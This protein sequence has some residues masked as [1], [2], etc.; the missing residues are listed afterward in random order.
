MNQGKLLKLID[1]LP[2]I[3]WEK[4]VPLSSLTT[5]KVGGPARL[6]CYPKSEDEVVQAVQAARGLH[7]P[8]HVLG[9]GSNVLA[10]DE[11]FDGLLIILTKYMR[12]LSF[13]GFMLQCEA[14][15]PIIQ[16]SYEAANRGLSGLEFACGIPGSIGGAVFMNAGAYECSIDSVFIS[17]RC[18]DQNNNIVILTKNEMDFGYRKSR[19]IDEGLIILSV[20]LQL[21]A[22]HKTEI[23]DLMQKYNLSRKQKQPLE[24]PS[25]GSFFKRPPGHYA[26]ALI[27]QAGLKGFR[28]NG[29]MVSE[30]HA[31]FLVNAGNAT[32]ADFLQLCH[33]IQNTIHEQYG[34]RL[35][36]EVQLL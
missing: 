30:K 16:C 10:K 26:G 14:G 15:I 19:A 2:F 32:S 12:D 23:L 4:N 28:V 9:F 5:I 20:T 3:E 21:Q 8:F 11:G 27:E 34:I 35:E 6:V 1:S 22:G 25:A 36:T 31:G 7:L 33:I 18:I 17:C 13:D 24:F 29:A